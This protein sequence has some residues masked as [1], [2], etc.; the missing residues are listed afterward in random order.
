LILIEQDVALGSLG[1]NENIVNPTQTDDNKIFAATRKGKSFVP[2]TK[3]S[4]P[5]AFRAATVP[6]EPTYQSRDD[7]NQKEKPPGWIQRTC[8]GENCSKRQKSGTYRRKPGTAKGDD[9][10]LCFTCW[11]HDHTKKQNKKCHVCDA[12]TT[13]SAWYR[14]TLFEGKDLCQSCYKDER[15]TRLE[16]SGMMQCSSCGTDN[17]SDTWVLSKDKSEG[18]KYLCNKCRQ[19]EKGRTLH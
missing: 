19:K 14:S 4:N 11:F 2:R 12:T 8:V 15:Q 3:F 17:S 5:F 16:A 10:Y 13:T 9:Q 18:K 7:T 6:L 1:G